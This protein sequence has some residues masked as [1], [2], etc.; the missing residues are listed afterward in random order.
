MEQLKAA[1]FDKVLLCGKH[2]SNVGQAFAPYPDTEELMEAL[3]AQPLKGYHILIKG[4][5]SMGLEKV[6]ERL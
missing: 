1:G 5:H 2:F 4:S 3:K 6:A